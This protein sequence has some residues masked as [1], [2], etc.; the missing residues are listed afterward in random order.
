M[1]SLKQLRKALGISQDEMAGLLGLNKGRVAMAEI[2]KRTLPDDARMFVAWMLDELDA[3]PDSSE[4]QLPAAE[5]IQKEIRRME[6]RLELLKLE[7]EN[8][9]RIDQKAGFLKFICDRFENR[10]PTDLPELAKNTV[11][12]LKSVEDLRRNNQQM[13][14][15][16]FL[17]AKIKGL[18]AAIA[19]LKTAV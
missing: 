14:A 11:A 15:P 5:I 16:L 8:R 2:G 19:W 9:G 12:V 10:F 1:N 7:L 6:I 17:Q 4:T 3:W 18:E 13:D